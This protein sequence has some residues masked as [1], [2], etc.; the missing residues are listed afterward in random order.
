MR[1]RN[2]KPE[3]W[4][5]ADVARLPMDLRLLYVGLWS[6]VDDN[7][8]G[9]DDYVLIT[10][11][12]FPRE[13]DPVATREWVREG[14]QRLSRESR[15]LRYEVGGVAYLYVLNFDRH[16]RVHNPN[17]PRL[18]L[19]CGCVADH[20]P[21]KPAGQEDAALIPLATLPRVSAGSTETLGTGSGGQGV[22]GS[23]GQREMARKRATRISDDFAP[24]EAMLA[25]AR[26]ER[27]DINAG[28]ETAKFVDYWRGKSGAQAT[29]LDW[30]ATWRNWIRSARAAPGPLRAVSGGHEP[31][32]NPADQSAYD[33]DL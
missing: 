18:P 16:Q 12:L 30:A 5:S 7:G 20:R 8:V 29:K 27:P 32:R 17:K 15:C 3:F 23:E 25:W 28:F 13:V 6:Y 19:P 33:E 1:I 4:R 31:Y 10:S 11:D 26:K 22:R 2:I 9:V 24:T 14:L 21:C